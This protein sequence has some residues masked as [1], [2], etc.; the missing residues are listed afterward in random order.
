M[1]TSQKKKMERLAIRFRRSET[2]LWARVARA[3]H[4]RA[5]TLKIKENGQY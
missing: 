1:G 5:A 3:I 2:M 4:K